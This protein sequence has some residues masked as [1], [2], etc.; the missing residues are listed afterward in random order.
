MLEVAWPL[1]AAACARGAVL[2]PAWVPAWLQVLL[3]V[4][5]ALLL[6]QLV[7]VACQS[8]AGS[9]VCAAAAAVGLWRIGCVGGSVLPGWRGA[10]R[11][12]GALLECRGAH[13][14]HH[15]TALLRVEHGEA[16]I[17]HHQNDS[18]GF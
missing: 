5:P 4:L 10:G 9:L 1:L 8:S 6:V 13:L 18:L 14:Q 16:V 2:Q 17:T 11:P 3:L 7:P 12:A 15:S